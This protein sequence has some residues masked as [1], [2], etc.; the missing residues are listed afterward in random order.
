MYFARGVARGY[1][2]NVNILIS[3]VPPASGEYLLCR[4]PSKLA[5][6]WYARKN[7]TLLILF[8]FSVRLRVFQTFWIEIPNFRSWTFGDPRLYHNH[9]DPSGVNPGRGAGWHVLLTLCRKWQCLVL[10]QPLFYFYNFGSMF[11]SSSSDAHAMT[12]LW[13]SHP[14]FAHL[15]YIFLASP[16]LKPRNPRGHN[17]RFS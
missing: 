1:H 2:G 8:I 17:P 3:H 5:V 16:L 14:V 11:F 15:S 9:D 7:D 12:I 4:D 13:F 6:Y 10:F